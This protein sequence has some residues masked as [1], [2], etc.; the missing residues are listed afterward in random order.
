PDARPDPAGAT[1]APSRKRPL[2]WLLAAAAIAVA[3]AAWIPW[4]T[5]PAAPV[6][7][8][9]VATGADASLG[10]QSS[11]IDMSRDGRLLAFAAQ[12]DGVTRLYIRRLDQLQATPLAGTEGGSGL[13]FSPDGR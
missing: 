2:P 7:R 10:G 1:A 4:R 11:T 12:K 3:A 5:V 13:F 6:T 8:V 9:L